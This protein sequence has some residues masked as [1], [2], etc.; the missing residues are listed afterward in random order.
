M[1]QPI[2]KH[3]EVSIGKARTA[4]GSENR[5]LVTEERFPVEL[6][7]SHRNSTRIAA[8]PRSEASEVAR[9]AWNA[10]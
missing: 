4:R 5:L 7:R 8:S 2:Q 1:P 9:S 3:R 6:E 10:C